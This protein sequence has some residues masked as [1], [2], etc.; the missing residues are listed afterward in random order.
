MSN[1][2]HRLAAASAAVGE[3]LLASRGTPPGSTPA[4][5]ALREPCADDAVLADPR[6]WLAGSPRMAALLDAHDSASAPGR[7]TGRLRTDVLE[8]DPG[9]RAAAAA[10]TTL[11]QPVEVFLACGGDDRQVPTD[12]LNSYGMPL[13]DRSP[14]LRASSCTATPPDGEALAVAQRWRD[15][16]LAEVLARGAAPDAETLRRS[17]AERFL[18]LL[19]LPVEYADRVV[20]TPSGTDVESLLTALAFGSSSRDLLVVTVGA[21]EAGSGTSSAA[22]LRAFRASAPFAVGLQA[23]HELPGVEAARVRVVDVELRDAAGRVRH[24]RDIQA[25]VEA[26]AEETIGEGA[27]VLVHVMD[28]SKTGLRCPDAAWVRAMLGRHRHE[29]RV[30]VDSAQ[31]RSSARHLREHLAAGAALFLTG[32]KA[33]GAPP[34]CGVLVLDDRLLS[35]AA[36]AT[37]GLPDG[38]AVAVA[39]GD[40]PPALAGLAGPGFEPVNLALLARWEVGLAEWTRLAALPGD[41]RRAAARDLLAGWTDGLRSLPGVEV[42][43]HPDGAVPTVLSLRVEDGAG[44][45]LGKDALGEVYARATAAP[46]VYLGQPVELVQGRHAV[47]RLA[48]GAPTVTRLVDRAETLGGLDRAVAEAVGVAVERIGGGLPVPVHR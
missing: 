39:R 1:P 9:G 12:G 10:V 22:G 48:V 38:L 13:A 6:L 17:V 16:L 37:A 3:A 34:F 26:H 25:E 47:L 14:S 41:R 45:W 11:A 43:R 35:D 27:R 36:G 40:L 20:L 7:D 5:S 21:R 4:A 29:L 15:A 2:L 30:V 32:S 19:R 24:A 8:L 33:I 46:G 42:L 28:G 18:H 44:G 31:A 23:G